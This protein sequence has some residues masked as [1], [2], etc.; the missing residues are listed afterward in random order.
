MNMYMSG[1][2]IMSLGI[3]FDIKKRNLYIILLIDFILV[4]ILMKIPLPLISLG[5]GGLFELILII[6]FINTILIG[7]GI[8]SK[9]F[10]NKGA[11]QVRRNMV[12]L[13]IVA[14]ATKS[15]DH[16]LVRFFYQ[17]PRAYMIQRM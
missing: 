2:F 6:T 1:L 7:L 13:A 12:I 16:M 4:V 8:H 14:I 17:N 9:I 5:G 15:K 10:R 3:L 11:R